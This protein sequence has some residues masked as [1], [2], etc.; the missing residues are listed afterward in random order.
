M[1][2]SVLPIS[3]TWTYRLIEELVAVQGWGRASGSRLLAQQEYRGTPA[4]KLAL[5]KAS[6]SGIGIGLPEYILLRVED[7][8][9]LAVFEGKAR[10]GDIAEAVSDAIHYGDALYAAGFQPLAIAVAG[11]EDPSFEVRVLKRI[12]PKWKPITYENE[13]ISWMP[14]PDEMDRILKTAGSVELRPRVPPPEVLREKAEEINGLLRESGLKDDFRPAV[15][16]AIMLALWQDGKNIRREPGYI[17]HDINTACSKAFWNAKKADLAQSIKVDEANQKLARRAS[18]ICQILERLNITTLTAEHDYIGALYEEFFRYTGGNTI[19]QYFTPR[20]IAR[21][22]AELCAVTK[23]DVTL[24]IACGTGGFLIAAMH[25]MQETSH[26]SRAQIVKIVG[27]KLIGIEA[28]P[29]TA[30]LC[31][32]NMILRGDGTTGIRKADAFDDAKF[33]FNTADICLM[34]PPFPHKKTDDPPEK[35]V[36]RALEGLKRKGLAAIIVPNSLLVKRSKKG[37]RTETLRHHRLEAVFTLPNELFQPYASATTGIILLRKGVPHGNHKTFFC[38]ITND[39]FRL[40]KGTRVHVPGSTLPKALGNF[41]LRDE[42]P[43]FCST[44]AVDEASGGW[45]PGAY[46]KALPLSYQESKKIIGQV[47]RNRSAFVVRFAP[48]LAVLDAELASDDSGL[49]V[50]PLKNVRSIPA[51]PGTIGHYFTIGYGQK[52]LHSKEA[53][54]EGPALVVSSSGLD[55]GCYGFFDFSTLIAPPFVTVPS[56]GS[57][58]EAAVQTRACGVVDDCL[59]LVPKPGTPPQ[60]LY[61]AAATLRREAWRFDYGRKMT[62]T[63]IAE[64]PLYLDDT[65][66]GWIRE[67]AAKAE[68]IEAEAL[69]GLASEA[70]T[71]L[72][73]RWDAEIASQRLLE[74]ES[75]RLGLISGSGLR[76]RLAKLRT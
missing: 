73:D 13:P 22:M 9:P 63:R 42:E 4:L 48:Q 71:M 20:H 74:I 49:T 53:L 68:S 66:R 59:V 65:L 60:M 27:S 5:A 15:I 72:A 31:V 28:E 56:T 26:I 70:E 32:A 57:I 8:Q 25:R 44:A 62:P 46:I 54:G 61:V 18:R 52:E 14:G 45:A 47:L 34:N 37:W 2:A 29:V 3:E 17:L 6:K 39:G 23:D 55:N 12:G 7:E 10:A 41:Q 58:G 19:G 76:E 64:L 33:P 38:R 16:G 11:T 67:Q 40:K 24:D 75:G 30:A 21:F 50:R 69:T 1:A 43:E 51:G 36:S 35:F